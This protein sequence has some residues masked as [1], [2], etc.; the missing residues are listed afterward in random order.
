MPW[1]LTG[2][3]G[4]G[5]DATERTLGEMNIEQGKIRF[6]SL[7]DDTLTWT[8][9]TLNATGAGALIP[10]FGQVVSAKYNGAQQFRGHVT[11]VKVGLSSVTVTV[12]GPWWWMTR[13][14]LVSEIADLSGATA[15]RPQYVFQTGDLA[16]NVRNLINRAAA[17]G[18]PMGL[19][20]IAPMYAVPRITVS[21][22]S[23]AEALA[24]L[25]SRV[26]DAVA[27]FDY[28]YTPPRLNVSRRNGAAAMEAI[29]FTV[30]V[31]RVE[32]LDLSPRL[33]LEIE[34]VQLPHM[35][36]STTGLPIY[37]VQTAGTSTAGK[38]QV[39]A[40]S[41][42]EVVANLPLESYDSETVVTQTIS[43]TLVT[44]FQRDPVLK[45][46]MVKKGAFTFV[47]DA[48]YGMLPNLPAA[49]LALY[50]SSYPNELLSNSIPE[51]VAA[52]KGILSGKTRIY[53]ILYVASTGSF[54]PVPPAI[55]YLQTINRAWV[56]TRSEAGGTR[57]SIAVLVDYEV[58]A[59]NQPFPGGQTIY[60]KADYDFMFPPAGMAAGLR[61][62]QAW[63]PWEGLVTLVSDSV[64]G[65]NL[66]GS[67][68][69]ISGTLPQCA[70]MRTLMRGVT[71]DLMR[72]RMDLEVGAPARLDYGTAVG[73]V[74]TNPQ[75][76]IVTL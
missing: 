51:W 66:L 13:V 21:Q 34:A 44:S 47:E 6:Q 58:D 19:G 12:A 71:Y 27:W 23:C 26:P 8:V 4:K 49:G 3:A 76:V 55:S 33:D 62:A 35:R 20:T 32:S 50:G 7:A 9:R 56:A 16:T 75:D 42:P 14:P 45:D 17:D 72:G 43:R 40:V 39:V 63:V 38:L 18:V 52:E 70:T 11:G 46:A 67:A 68:L 10:S 30:G 31:D 48:D 28:S 1:T 59:I 37:A 64:D 69:N 73:R 57:T 74:S 41:G 65:Q 53:G 36:R 2:E 54:P 22:L 15:T 25:L 24:K 61:T 29:S 60:K 5:L